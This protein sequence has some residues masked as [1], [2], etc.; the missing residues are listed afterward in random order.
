[1]LFGG[2]P[3]TDKTIMVD[4]VIA[5]VS[6]FN[7]GEVSLATLRAWS[8]EAVDAIC[9]ARLLVTKYVPM[10]A[11]RDIRERVLASLEERL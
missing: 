7:E 4:R 9:A 10:L 6:R 3:I 5:H 8:V 11:I 2:T 1:M